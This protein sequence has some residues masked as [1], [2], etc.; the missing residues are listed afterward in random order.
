MSNPHL[1][2]RGDSDVEHRAGL[3]RKEF[4]CCPVDKAVATKY[5]T[6]VTGHYHLEVNLRK[7]T[8]DQ[9]HFYG[10]TGKTIDT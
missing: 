7:I 5:A 2:V 6:Y 8:V 10:Q 4:R 1:L 3:A 9:P